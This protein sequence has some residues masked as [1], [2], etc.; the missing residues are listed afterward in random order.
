VY[1]EIAVDNIIKLPHEVDKEKNNYV[2]E[3]L[4]LIGG[5]A[6]NV[7]VLLALWKV[8]VSLSGY[9]LGEDLYGQYIMDRMSKYPYLDL[10]YVIL[11]KGINTSFCRILVPPNGDRYILVFNSTANE[12]E[13]TPL[14][15]KMLGQT[16]HFVADCLADK[17]PFLQA[18]KLAHEKGLCIIGSDI[19]TLDSTLIPYV[20]V[21]CNSV[22]VLNN[23]NGISDPLPYS[24]KLHHANGA[25]VITTNGP[26]AVH[27]IDRDSSEF[28]AHPVK[29]NKKDILDTTGA[30]DALKA[31]VTYGLVQG[32]PLPDAVRYG[33]AAGSLIIQSV[34]AVSREPTVE[35]V[36]TCSNQIQITK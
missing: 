14:T 21:I 25:I 3:D 12:E 4:I 34:G 19:N 1:G 16:T 36:V 29:I 20:N 10:R 23:Q 30:G 7:A 31:G 22:G 26:R 24:K 8:K 35:E 33:M 13:A 27:V 9:A 17:K 11:R 18:V 32:W 15:N 5:M 6:S 2:L 28:W